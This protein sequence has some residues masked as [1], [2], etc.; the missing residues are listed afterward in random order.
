VG[1]AIF[2]SPF[3]SIFASE[4]YHDGYRVVGYVAFSSLIWQLSQMA[5]YGILIKKRTKQIAINQFVAAFVNVGLN[6]LLVPLYGYVV[7]GITTL[8]GYLILLGLQAYSSR[9][10]LRW[11]FP[12]V[13]MRNTT[14]ATVFMSLV[15]LGI[16]G[17]S[18]DPMGLHITLLLLSIAA[19]F[20]VYFLSLW[21]LGEAN[22]VEKDAVI[23]WIKHIR[24][25]LLKLRIRYGEE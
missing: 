12:W 24:D 1:L 15:A 2:A 20:L 17:L 3:V 16:Y 18:K 7:A 8:V 21:L 10:D 22:E 6:L 19:A 23:L 5:S 4:A 14:I 13:T 25:S 11:R 9:N